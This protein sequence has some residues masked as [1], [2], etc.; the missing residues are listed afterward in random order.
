[1]NLG[2]ID[3]A[4]TPFECD[5]HTDALSKIDHLS[6]YSSAVG[7]GI[8]YFSFAPPIRKVLI[9]FSQPIS[10]PRRLAQELAEALGRNRRVMTPA[11]ASQR[12]ATRVLHNVAQ[13]VAQ[14]QFHEMFV[15]RNRICLIDLAGGSERSRTSDLRFRKPFRLSICQ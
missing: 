2:C 8:G 14:R 7:V 6:S 11:S 3:R 5:V 4:P 1:M 9:V 13:D 12:P 15:S 10:L